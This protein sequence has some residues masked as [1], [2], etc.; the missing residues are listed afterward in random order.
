MLNLHPVDKC[1]DDSKFKTSPVQYESFR[2][3]ER[4]LCF[5]TV[6]LRKSHQTICHSLKLVIVDQMLVF[7]H[8]SIFILQHVLYSLIL[9]SWPRYWQSWP[10][11]FSK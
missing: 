5:C 6:C 3:F 4:V 11:K 8:L 7:K 10:V 9:S 2:C 1:E